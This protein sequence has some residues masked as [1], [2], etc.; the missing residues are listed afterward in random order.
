MFGNKFT[1][2]GSQM[3]FGLRASIF[4]GRRSNLAR[5]DQPARISCTTSPWTSVRRMSRP[6]NR[7]VRRL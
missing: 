3:G 6:P 1:R 2:W 7:N 4:E 5:L